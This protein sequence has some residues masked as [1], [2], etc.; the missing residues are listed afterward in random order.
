MREYIFERVKNTTRHFKFGNVRVHE[1]DPMPDS[2]D[3]QAV[4]KTIEK[5]FPPFYFK[6]L[7][8]INIQ[9]IPEFDEREVNAVYKDGTFYITN[10][11]DNSKDLMDD[12][13]HEF[14]HHMEIKFPEL[15]YSDETLINEFRRKRQELNFELRSEG[16]WTDEYDFHNLK[17]DEDFDKFLYKRVGKNMLQMVTAGMFIRPY[18]SISLREYFATG[19]EAYYLGQE[20]TLERI[21]PMLYNKINELHHYGT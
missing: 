7:K 1:I 14:A 8:E 5:S 2:I 17:F 18:A 15:I 4:L 16:Y 10:K 20:N 19:F 11:Q 13:I 9:H 21:S 12:I 6:D 3:L